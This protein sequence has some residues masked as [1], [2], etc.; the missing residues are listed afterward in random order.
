MELTKL[1]DVSPGG[2]RATE[3]ET[4]VSDTNPT[5]TSK[6]NLTRNGDDDGVSNKK[7][8][9]ADVDDTATDIGVLADLDVSPI[10]PKR[11]L[12]ARAH[13]SLEQ[14]IPAPNGENGSESVKTNKPAALISP[15]LTD[16]L[17][18]NVFCSTQK[19]DN[20]ELLSKRRLNTLQEKL[21][22]FKYDEGEKTAGKQLVT[23]LDLSGVNEISDHDL[24]LD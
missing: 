15:Q 3:D 24:E 14:N 1:K 10:Y 21:S 7:N 19:A 9:F 8:R 20:D 17:D 5:I 16:Q 6:R 2:D 12:T 11:P 4:S 13:T 22:R 23:L 18:G